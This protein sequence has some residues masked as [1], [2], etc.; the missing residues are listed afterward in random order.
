[1]A[2]KRFNTG[3]SGY[4][5]NAYKQKQDSLYYQNW[6]FVFS[7]YRKETAKIFLSKWAEV[8]LKGGGERETCGKSEGDV[9]KAERKKSGSWSIQKKKSADSPMADARWAVQ[10]TRKKRLLVGAETSS[11]IPEFGGTKKKCKPL[12]S[13]RPL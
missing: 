9:E 7:C 3:L 13:E 10:T 8:A 6:A 1:L 5:K 2:R 4:S 11:H 12:E